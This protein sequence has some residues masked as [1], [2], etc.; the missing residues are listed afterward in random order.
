[1]C[2]DNGLFI[3]WQVE[4]EVKPDTS[5]TVTLYGYSRSW[6]AYKEDFSGMPLV[7]PGDVYGEDLAGGRVNM[8]GA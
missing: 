7:I 6:F 5:S 3:R 2:E 1:M 4:P 8:I